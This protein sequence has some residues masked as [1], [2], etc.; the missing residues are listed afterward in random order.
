MRPLL[1]GAILA[2]AEVDLRALDAGLATGS[3]SSVSD[4]TAWALL[5]FAGN[6]STGAGSIDALVE[7][8]DLLGGIFLRES[9]I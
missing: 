7:R 1:A 4:S 3:L 6:V 2:L 8:D 5:R 9:P